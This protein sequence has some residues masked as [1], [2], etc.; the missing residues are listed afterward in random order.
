[1][2]KLFKPSFRMLAV[3][4][5]GT[6]AAIVVGAMICFELDMFFQWLMKLAG[7]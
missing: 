1:M 4:V 6:L 7:V 3:K 2:D 5:I